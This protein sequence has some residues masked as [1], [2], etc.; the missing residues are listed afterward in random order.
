VPGAFLAALLIGQLQAFGVL[1][2]PKITLVLVFL[3]MAVVLVIKPWGL[4]G[5]PEAA[6]GRAVLPEGIIDPRRLDRASQVLVVVALAA[7]LALPLLDAYAVKVGTE[8]LILALAA[9]S[10]N[11]LVGNGGIVSFGHAAYFGLGAY[12]AGLLVTKAGLPM[13]PALVA[14]PIVAGAFAA[15]FGFFVVRLSGIYLAMLTLAFAQIAYAVVFQWVEVTGGDNGLVGV[16]PSRWAASR[17]VYHYIVAAVTVAAIILLRRVTHAPFGAT[18]RAARDSA[19][20]A[21]AIGVDVRMH[22][23]LGF[24]LAGSAAG[25]AGGLYAFSKGSIDPTLL[26]IP[27]SVDFLSMLLLG[28]IQSVLGPIAGAAAFH[29][30]KDFFM[31]LTDHWRLFLGLS[32]IAMVLVFPRGLAGAWASLRRRPA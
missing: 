14:A 7:V 18:L 27:M 23:W 2:F 13:E 25:L 30:V 4:L 6:A 16:W 20:R 17:E 11:F 3:L 28:G 32:I 10:L 26:G 5:K 21:D 15:L 9:F 19:Q 24:T 8:V 31:P 29:A 1:I 22:R 12:G